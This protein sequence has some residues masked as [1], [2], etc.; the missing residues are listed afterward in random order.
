M[1]YRPHLLHEPVNLTHYPTA[2]MQRH[3]SGGGAKEGRAA[4]HVLQHF[5]QRISMNAV[6]QAA[7]DGPGGKTVSAYCLLITVKRLWHSG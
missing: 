7:R 2:R 4:A 1:F 3:V 6:V 5:R